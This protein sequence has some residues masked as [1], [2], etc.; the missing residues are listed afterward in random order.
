MGEPGAPA[1]RVVRGY[2]RRLPLAFQRAGSPR[3]ASVVNRSQVV[4]PTAGKKRKSSAMEE[5]NGG[6]VPRS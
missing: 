3:G 5:T 2:A 6:R 4:I 1:N